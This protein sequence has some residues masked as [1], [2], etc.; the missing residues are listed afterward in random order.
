MPP[1]Y[2]I[3][4]FSTANKPFSC[5]ELG[6]L[7]THARAY[8]KQHHITG[9]LLY[10]DNEFLQVIEGEYFELKRLFER[11]ADD[12]RHG[13]LRVLSNGP[14]ERP[15]FPDWRMGFVGDCA[16]FFGK[17]QGCIHLDSPSLLATAI[18]GATSMLLALLADF[19]QGS[20]AEHMPV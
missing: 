10:N 11:I 15:T 17:A 8:N 19:A 7:L 3:V 14:L 5:A 6:E 16:E 1:L 20:Y 9:L 2:Q 18:P 13:R 12:P 4:Y